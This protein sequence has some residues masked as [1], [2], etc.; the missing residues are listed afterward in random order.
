MISKFGPQKDEQPILNNSLKLQFAQYLYDQPAA[1]Y[2]KQQGQQGKPTYH[3][4]GV[5]NQVEYQGGQYKG[6]TDDHT[7]IVPVI[8]A[9]F[10][11]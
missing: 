1:G 11:A 8:S 2:A 9:Y 7:D 5:A 10:P 6:A 3:P 4:G